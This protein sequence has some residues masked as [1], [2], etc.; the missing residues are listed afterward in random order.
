[1]HANALKG[2]MHDQTYTKLQHMQ[3][4]TRNRKERVKPIF[5]QLFPLKYATAVLN[6]S[7]CSKSM[8]LSQTKLMIP[9]V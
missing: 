9:R 1:M 8:R 6:V 2:A 3:T 4:N 5:F 7:S